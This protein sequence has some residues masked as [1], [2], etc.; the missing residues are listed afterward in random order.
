[1][2]ELSNVSYAVEN[3]VILDKISLKINSGELVVITGPNGGGK[4]TLVETIMGIRC[5]NKGKIFFDDED[6]TKLEVSERAKRGVSFAFQRPIKIKGVTVRDL[7]EIASGKRTVSK[8]LEMVGLK[9]EEYL[10]REIED[11]LSGGE[12]KRIEVASVIARGSKLMIFDEPEAGIDL[13]S[14]KNLVEMFKKIRKTGRAMIIVSH[15]ERILKIADRIIVLENGKIKKE[16]IKEEI[17]PI[18]IGGKNG[19]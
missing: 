5:P 6:I 10:E 15:Q 12:L 7:L 13:W 17:F 1:M 4:S 11:R 16:G 2:L 18:L 19:N 8:Y 3:K 14:F 9:P